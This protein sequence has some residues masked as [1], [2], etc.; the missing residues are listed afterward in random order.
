MG[1]VNYGNPA[2]LTVAARGRDGL[3]LAWT[4]R[5]GNESGFAV[6]R[7][8]ESEGY[9]QV[10]TVGPNATSYT[11]GG[12]ARRTT[13]TYRVRAHNAAGDSAYSNEASGTTK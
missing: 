1:M 6:E 5:A 4:D 7:R 11:D 13:Y 2:G 9:V 8:T 12:L 10:A 3:K